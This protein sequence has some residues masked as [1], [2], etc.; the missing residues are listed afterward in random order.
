MATILLG[1][2]VFCKEDI[3]KEDD[4]YLQCNKCNKYACAACNSPN[5]SD[6]GVYLDEDSPDYFC[7]KKCLKKYCKNKE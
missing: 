1:V 2:C 5:G 3:F 7:S 4:D 6:L